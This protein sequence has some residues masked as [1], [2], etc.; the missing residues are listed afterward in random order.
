MSLFTKLF[1][2]VH[3]WRRRRGGASKPR[4]RSDLAMEQL[5]HRQLLTVN[6]TG[7]VAIDFPATVN[8][9]VVVVASPITPPFNQ[10]PQIPPAL[11]GVINVSG[12]EIDQ[13]RVNYDPLADILSVGVE[14]PSN[15]KTGQPV[16]AADSDNN[17]NSG[18]VNPSVTAI[19]PTF[20]DPP[21]MG[22]TKTYGVSFNFLNT[23][24]PQVVAG[25]PQS[26]P[27]GVP[28]QQGKVFEVAAAI[29][30]PGNPTGSPSFDNTQIFPQ[31]AGNYYLANDP[32]HPNFEFQVA[33]FSQ[34]YQ[35]FSGHALTPTSPLGIGA[36]ASN[37][38]D[39]GLS[40]Q[41]FPIQTIPA[42]QQTINP[43]I[44]PPIQ[45]CSPTIFVNYHQSNHINTAHPEA[46]RVT[47]LGSSG[48]DPTT[49][50]PSTVKFG[51]PNTIATTGASPILSFENNVNHDEFPDETFVFNGLD[52]KLPSGITNAEITG[53]TKSGLFINS[54]VKVFN[55]DYSYYT[56]AEINKQQTSFLAYDKKHGIDTT[57]G[58][59][60]PPPSIPNLAQQRANT[61]AINDLYAPFAGQVL[62][63]QVNPTVGTA[64]AAS[65]DQ[66][67]VVVSIPTRG[68]ARKG[69][70]VTLSSV[71]MGHP[72]VATAPSLSGGA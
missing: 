18:T 36:F 55:R 57:N 35:Q 23:T 11:Q 52:V 47:V 59:V 54:Q 21:N 43:P 27:L 28:V 22:G 41:F 48:F 72:M 20:T 63:K 29:T 65:I 39:I 66:P 45:T 60:A 38:Q 4:K 13:M 30:A 2:A 69:Q 8:P 68:R 44:L 56:P 64:Q 62:P 70:A 33:H 17:L 12:L 49:L 19:E 42:V 3:S 14:G 31:Y 46:I 9:G 5:D 51:D 16:I 34:L 37:N 53:Q 26:N 71:K 1:Q 6:F 50:I 58:A 67:P 15:G 32:N 7:N 25:F 40:D 10:T 61:M 24:V